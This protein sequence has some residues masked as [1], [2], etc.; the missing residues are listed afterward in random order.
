MA[1]A[2]TRM[3]SSAGF[4]R[5]STPWCIEGGWFSCKVSRAPAARGGGRRCFRARRAKGIPWRTFR[6]VMALRAPVLLG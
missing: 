2:T 5:Y 1:R 4:L 6:M 3:S